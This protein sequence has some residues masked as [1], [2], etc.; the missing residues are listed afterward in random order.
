MKLGVEIMEK[1]CQMGSAFWRKNTGRKITCQ[2]VHILVNV[3][4][5]L[6]SRLW[7]ATEIT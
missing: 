7:K 6:Y 1:A 5:V 4:D 2:I 3:L